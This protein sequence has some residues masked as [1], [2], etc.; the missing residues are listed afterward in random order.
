[1]TTKTGIASTTAAS[2]GSFLLTLLPESD[3]RAGTRRVSR[4]KTLDGGV[5]ITDQGF[6]HGDRTLRLVARSSET[7]WAALWALFQ[8]AALQVTVSLADGC[9]T[10]SLDQISE[11]DG[12]IKLSVLLKEKISA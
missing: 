12:K 7:L 10:G 3:L 9:F 4:T 6:A 5:V 8:T 1:M 2:A 11:A